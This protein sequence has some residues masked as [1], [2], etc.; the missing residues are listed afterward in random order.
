MRFRTLALMISAA[1]FWLAVVARADDA[2]LFQEKV[3][4]I[5]ERRCVQ[6]HQ[7]ATPKGKLSLETAA[8]AL[9]G[10]ESGPAIVPGKPD[11]SLLVQMIEGDEPLMPK[12]A[13]PLSAEEV[14]AVRD[15]IA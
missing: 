14:A 9:A 7:G 8:E 5:F 2:V 11:E 15:W 1:C 10:G 12:G 3:A 6:C 4:P 13:K